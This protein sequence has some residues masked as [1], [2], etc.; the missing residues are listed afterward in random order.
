MNKILVTKP[1]PQLLCDEIA[2]EHSS[3]KIICRAEDTPMASNDLVKWAKK[4]EPYGLVVTL[5]EK[6]SADFVKELPGTVKVISTIAVGTDNID[7]DACNK[8]GIQVF[9]T[10]DVLTDATADLTWA[11]I[12]ATS[13]RL[14][15]GHKMCVEERF[16]GWSPTL[17]MGK[18]LCGATLGIIGLGRI[19]S[20]VARR[21]FGFGMKVVY[22]NRNPVKNIEERFPNVKNAPEYVSIDDIC[23]YSDVISLHCPLNNESFHLFNEERLLKCKDDSVLVNMARGSV[24]DEEALVKVLGGGHFMGVGLDVFEKEPNINVN[25]KKFDRVVLLPHIGSSTTA[26]RFKMIRLAIESVLTAYISE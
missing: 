19:G 9:N 25:L 5:T 26:T 13:R 21:A 11:L 15:E 2:R 20:A 1:I 23:K 3:L 22:S 24:I 17:L 8:R 6:C 4:E 14:I 7:I 18:E 12:L 10:P 16:K